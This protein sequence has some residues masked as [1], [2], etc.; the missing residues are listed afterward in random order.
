MQTAL[1][2]HALR[3][4]PYVHCLKHDTLSTT[5]IQA[6]SFQTSGLKS[7]LDALCRYIMLLSKSSM[8]MH[9]H[10]LKTFNACIHCV[11]IISIFGIPLLVHQSLI[12]TMFKHITVTVLYEHVS[13]TVNLYFQNSVSI[14]IGHFN[15]NLTMQSLENFSQ[16]AL[17]TGP[18]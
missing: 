12:N 6:S 14:F 1:D 13:V 10:G 3:F 17:I 5:A 4:N 18:I 8:N 11:K 16:R 7:I 9:V 15:Q 2:A